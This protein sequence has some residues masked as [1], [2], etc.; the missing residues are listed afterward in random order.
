MEKFPFIDILTHSYTQKFSGRNQSTTSTH[1]IQISYMLVKGITL[2]YITAKW[3]K[4]SS[5]K[6][7]TEVQTFLSENSYHASHSGEHC[8]FQLNYPISFI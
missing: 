5:W 1:T 7:K 4:L 3:L 8:N 2:S 6:N